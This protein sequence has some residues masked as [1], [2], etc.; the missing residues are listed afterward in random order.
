MHFP[1]SHSWSSR[2]FFGPLMKCWLSIL[3][4][5]VYMCWACCSCPLN[6]RN[7]GALLSSSLHSATTEP[8]PT[9]GTCSSKTEHIT[10]KILPIR[11]GIHDQCFTINI[12]ARWGKITSVKMD[13]TR[14]HPNSQR[15][16][17]PLLFLAEQRRKG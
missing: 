17:E 8:T 7:K 2:V 9:V 4:R 14:V 5:V 11:L 13:C 12:S 6:P 15:G 1:S 16:M 3:H 10:V